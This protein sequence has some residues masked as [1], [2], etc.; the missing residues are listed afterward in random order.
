MA[1]A[2][3][4]PSKLARKKPKVYQGHDN[5]RIPTRRDLKFTAPEDFIPKPEGM[6]DAALVEQAHRQTHIWQNEATEA[7]INMR[8]AETD[9]VRAQSVMRQAR[10]A[11]LSG[12]TV[13]ELVA[14]IDLLPQPKDKM[15]TAEMYQRLPGAPAELRQEASLRAASLQMA[16]SLIDENPLHEVEDRFCG[17]QDGAEW[18]EPT[19]PPAPRLKTMSVGPTN[20]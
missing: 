7:V 13:D 19:S 2:K 6:V 8:K 11:V 12:C 4:K 1:S 3:R 15:S 5:R 20:R 10:R 17:T 14:I 16:R 18:D 9:L